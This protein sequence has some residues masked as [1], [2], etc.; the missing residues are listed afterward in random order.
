M[1]GSQEE[2]KKET[3]ASP[4]QAPEPDKK[5]TEPVK[6]SEPKEDEVTT[7]KKQVEE[8]TKNYQ[9]LLKDNE[10]KEKQAKDWENKYYTVYADMANTRKQVEKENQEFKRYAVQST[11]QEI[12]PVLDSFDMALKNEPQDEKI[13]NYVAGFKMIHSKLLNV[14]KQL[15]IEIINP[16]VGEEF[17]PHSMEAFSTVDGEKDNLVAETFLKGYRL[18]DHLLRSAGVIITKKPIAVKEEK[19]EDKEADKT[20]ETT[21]EVK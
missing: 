1:N 9:D 13:K 11:I 14:L 4:E 21:K 7:L 10:A 8:L 19:K 16:Q 18:H 2:E 12:I 5:E 20:A 17:N 6:E 15:G 3:E